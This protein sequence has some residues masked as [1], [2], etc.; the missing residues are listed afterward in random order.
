MEECLYERAWQSLRELHEE[1]A[2]AG[3]VSLELCERR[4]R[5]IESCRELI[6]MLDEGRKR[7]GDGGPSDPALDGAICEAQVAARAAMLKSHDFIDACH[8]SR[9]KVNEAV[10]LAERFLRDKLDIGGVG[11]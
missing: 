7:H 3:R 6:G 2:A 1:I 9:V 10:Q 4:L 8:A 5:V 11:D